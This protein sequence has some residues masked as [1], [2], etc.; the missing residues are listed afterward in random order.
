MERQ[1]KDGPI[2]RGLTRSAGVRF[3]RGFK[4]SF[5]TIRIETKSQARIL[6]DILAATSYPDGHRASYFDG[7]SAES[8]YSCGRR[9]EK[10]RISVDVKTNCVER[11]CLHVTLSAVDT[12]V[13]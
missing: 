1:A 8:S 7:H 3:T 9:V 10:D 13:G 5:S 2:N 4:R 12:P 11:H 6:T